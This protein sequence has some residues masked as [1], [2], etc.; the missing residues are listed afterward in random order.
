MSEFCQDRDLMAVEPVIFTSGGQPGQQ[1]ASG[2]N[3]AVAGTAFTAAGA[4]FVSAGVQAG[5]VLCVWTTTPDE[6]AAYE[7]TAVVA[8]TQLTVSVLRADRAGAAVAPPAGTGLG[9][10]VVTFAAQIRGASATLAEK[11]RQLAEV[12]GVSSADFA[13]SAQLRT[14]AALAALAG[15]FLARASGGLHDDAN[16]TKAEKYARLALDVR[17]QLRL[18]VDADGDGR[19]E[20]TRTLADITLRRA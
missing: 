20:S 6:G 5:M 2:A 16:W 3:G 17:A 12:A 14:A 11:L 8:A 13:D 18:A 15:V 10:R 1:L 9:Y 4:D 19:A 7:I